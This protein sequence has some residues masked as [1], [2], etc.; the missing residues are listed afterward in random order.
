MEMKFGSQMVAR[1]EPE[2]MAKRLDAVELFGLT[3]VVLPKDPPQSAR[4]VPGKMTLVMSRLPERFQRDSE[5]QKFRK[6]GPDQVEVTITAQP[7]RLE[8]HRARP[9]ADPAGGENLKSSLAVESDRK[10]VRDLARKIL[11]DEKDAYASSEKIS[12]WVYEHLEKSYGTS[13]DRTTDV[14]RQM[15]GDCTEHA[16]LTVSLLRAAGIPAKRIDGVIYQ[17]GSDGVPALMWHEW[18]SAF[19]GEWVHLDPTWGQTVADAT[20]FAVGE[21]TNA[22]IAP[23]I[24]ELK[25]TD[26]R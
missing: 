23:L 21:E 18:V 17:K 2:A 1:A 24:G 16:L 11:G 19:V 7:P 20:H 15:K 9:L 26:V 22:E 6:V 5:R 4:D 12:R 14:L 13:A 8:K 3:R 25:V 10:E